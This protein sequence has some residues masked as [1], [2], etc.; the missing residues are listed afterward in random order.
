[1]K[2]ILLNLESRPDR[3]KRSVDELGK[4][5]I[6]QIEIFKAHT[7]GH[8][9]FN[10]SMHEIVMSGG[11]MLVVED[12]IKLIGNVSDLIAAKKQLPDDWDMLYLGANLLEPCPKYDTRIN[13]LTSAW[14][15]HAIL[16]SV[17]GSD[18]CAK[19]YDYS[20]V[21][22]EWLRRVAQNRLKCFVMNPLIAFQHPDISDL[23]GQ[24]SDYDLTDKG[25][26]I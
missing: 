25:M 22:D 11:E 19:F 9:G 24:Y 26:L 4:F 10:K 15:T 13:R 7:G 21:Y 12:D 17:K 16:Y 14:T 23:T 2:T 1:M 8:Y 20:L 3:L 6:D 5:G 18:Y